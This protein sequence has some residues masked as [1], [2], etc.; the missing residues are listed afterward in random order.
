M[1]GGTRA[2]AGGGGGEGE[3]VLEERVA[4]E[5]RHEALRVRLRR[6]R[7]GARGRQGG[8]GA[9]GAGSREAL[10]RGHTGGGGGK[11]CDSLGA[12]QRLP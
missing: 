9:R 7:F 2:E 5:A 6:A 12:C 1:T 10:L 11:R 8:G 3:P 4:P